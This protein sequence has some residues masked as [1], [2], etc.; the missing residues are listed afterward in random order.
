MFN[1]NK[2]LHTALTMLFK[3]VYPDF[4]SSCLAKDR[5][6]ISFI[7]RDYCCQSVM[8][9]FCCEDQEKKTPAFVLGKLF[10]CGALSQSTFDQYLKISNET[11]YSRD[12]ALEATYDMVMGLSLFD[13]FD[14]FYFLPEIPEVRENAIREVLAY[15]EKEG[16]SIGDDGRLVDIMTVCYD[17]FILGA[18]CVNN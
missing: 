17:I 2:T 14:E 7:G 4:A 1:T 5:K 11:E 6:E 8:E 10:D 3:K 9:A 16:I 13:K 18:V 12:R 15:L